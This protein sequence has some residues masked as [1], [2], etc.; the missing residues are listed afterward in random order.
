MKL[1]E[2]PLTKFREGDALKFELA[3]PQRAKF[4]HEGLK[5]SL[6]KGDVAAGKARAEIKWLPGPWF[7][8]K[9]KLEPWT[10]LGEVI[11]CQIHDSPADGVWKDHPARQPLLALKVQMRPKLAYRVVYG[12]ESKRQSSAWIQWPGATVTIVAGFTASTGDEGR[13]ELQVGRLT[14]RFMGPN[15]YPDT[16]EPYPK[17]GLYA[18]KGGVVSPLGCTLSGIVVATER[19]EVLG[20]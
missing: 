9:V 3:S 10:Y 14:H 20:A 15:D 2:N 13:G 8:L 1:Y 18:P 6:Q 19:A 17:A 12:T 11:V 7:R 4:T 16:G 5:L